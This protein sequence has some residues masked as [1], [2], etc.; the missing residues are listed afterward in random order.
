MV[1]VEQSGVQMEDSYTD[2][3]PPEDVP[4][5][6]HAQQPQGTSQHAGTVKGIGLGRTD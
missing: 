3:H 5:R 4:G 6:A 1:G 2:P